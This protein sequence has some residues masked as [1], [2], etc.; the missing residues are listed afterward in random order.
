M[1]LFAATLFL[2]SSHVAGFCQVKPISGTSNT[3]PLNIKIANIDAYVRDVDSNPKLSP[4]SIFDGPEY[5]INS[6]Y[7]KKEYVNSSQTPF[8]AIKIVT[9]NQKV[10]TSYYRDDKIVYTSEISSVHDNFS[11]IKNVYFEND[12]IIFSTN[13]LLQ[14]HILQIQ[15]SYNGAEQGGS[16]SLTIDKDSIK[17]SGSKK[18]KT[19]ISQSDWNRLINSFDL[20][21]FDKIKRGEFLSYIDGHDWSY[22]ITTD[23]RTHS[24]VNV[25]NTNADDNPNLKKM[26]EF[27]RQIDLLTPSQKN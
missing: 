16:F 22:V 13:T 17:C 4:I 11:N 14:E 8:R 20:T 19:K 5:K 23:K 3:A 26:A 15:Y 1:K 27:F 2:L 21:T 6:I 25:L 9:I 18:L 7:T 10:T 24:F 12:S